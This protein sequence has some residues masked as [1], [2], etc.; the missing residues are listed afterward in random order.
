MFSAFR[1]RRRRSDVSLVT[2]VLAALRAARVPGTP[3]P[4]VELPGSVG[5]ANLHADNLAAMPLEVTGRLTSRKRRQLDRPD[6]AEH[7]FYTTHKVV[8]S[9]WR[10]GNT[11]ALREGDAMRVLDPLQVGWDPDPDDPTRIVRWRYQG[12][13][14]PLRDLLHLKMNDAPDRG[15]L[16]RAPLDEAGEALAMYG[17]AYRYL[18]MFFEGG[19]NP[20]SV[21]QR[22]G[23]GNVLYSPE[24]AAED[25]IEARQERRPAVLP[26]GW[27]L[28]IPA[29]NGELEA[30]ARVLEECPGELAR[31]TNTPPTLANAK[32]GGSLVYATV[33]GEFRRW[34]ATSLKPTWICRLEIFYSEFLDEDVTLNT[35][36]MFDLV[37]PTVDD[38]PAPQ[39]PRQ[40]GRVLEAVA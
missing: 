2:E 40:A 30:I 4:P 6:P 32:V 9:A 1:A 12:R 27:E 15:P 3:I 13:P 34:L 38:E 8:Q 19:G 24:Q 25:W 23:A 11:W 17:H 36:G 20:S 10:R 26:Q 29:N 7:Q 18:V 21:L 14:V 35:E 33:A 5:L 16:G 22:T 39:A 31:A 37:D 28:K